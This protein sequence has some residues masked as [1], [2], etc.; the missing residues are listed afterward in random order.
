MIVFFIDSH[1]WA[2]VAEIAIEV[3]QILITAYGLFLPEIVP[4][5]TYFG[6]FA[7]PL[8]HIG[9]V[10]RL[11]VIAFNKQI[12]VGLTHSNVITNY[13]DLTVVLHMACYSYILKL[14]I[15]AWAWP[16]KIHNDF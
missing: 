6:S 8:P 13:N 4:R 15:T 14:V 16:F 10:C 11:G 1:F 5:F 2:E 12:D 3:L 7:L 9:W